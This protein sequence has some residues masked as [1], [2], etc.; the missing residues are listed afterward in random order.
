MEYS[1]SILDLTQQQE[2]VHPDHPPLFHE[3]GHE[4]KHFHQ[5]PQLLGVVR[6]LLALADQGGQRVR[7]PSLLNP[8]PTVI[9]VL[10]K[11]FM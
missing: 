11:L 4:E 2:Q 6:K 1:H 8:P 5:Q 7:S 3:Q 9:F 10:P